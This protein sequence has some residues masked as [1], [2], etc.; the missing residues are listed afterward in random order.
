LRYNLEIEAR[1]MTEYHQLLGINS[2]ADERIIKKAYRKKAF[3]FH[4]DIN[5]S[6]EASSHF[7][8]ITEAYEFL[9]HST[10]KAGFNSSIK[11]PFEEQMRHYQERAEQMAKMDFE[12]FQKECEAF[13]NSRF[14]YLGVV[15]LY[16]AGVIYL[17]ASAAL[18][19]LPIIIAVKTQTFWYAIALLPLALAGAFLYWKAFQEQSFWNQYLR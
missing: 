18:I 17:L 8:R 9:I 10:T 14:Y 15:L 6:P 7:I 5:K 19:C 4:P 2:Q 11:N 3:E 12:S 13:Q 16:I 1:K